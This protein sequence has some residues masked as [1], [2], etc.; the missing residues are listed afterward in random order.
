MQQY[1]AKF[2]AKCPVHLQ[3]EGESKSV[4][5]QPS[6]SILNAGWSNFT[7]AFPQL[8]RA[9]MLRT[10][11]FVYPTRTAW[12]QV[13]PILANAEIDAQQRPISALSGNPVPKWSRLY[14]A[15]RKQCASIA[16]F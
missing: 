6:V 1:F 9:S 5:S 16:E 15:Y 13:Y 4:L 11:K 10:R 2:Q 8:I 12:E 3:F 7:D 14:H